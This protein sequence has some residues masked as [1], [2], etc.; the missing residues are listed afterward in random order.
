MTP[1]CNDCNLSGK[2]TKI[3]T[4]SISSAEEVV[5]SY[6]NFTYDGA[7]TSYINFLPQTI[8]ATGTNFIEGIIYAN[9][10]SNME[11]KL[12]NNKAILEAQNVLLSSNRSKIYYRPFHDLTAGFLNLSMS[13]LQPSR[14]DLSSLKNTIGSPGAVRINRPVTSPFYRDDSPDYFQ[15]GEIKPFRA[16]IMGAVYS[17]ALL[18]VISGV[19]PAVGSFGGGTLITLFGHGFSSDMAAVTVYASGYPCDIVSASFNKILCRTRAP[20]LQL[21]PPSL[22]STILSNATAVFDSLSSNNS[23]VSPRVVRHFGSTGSWLY[24]SYRSESLEASVVL[25]SIPWRRSVSIDFTSLTPLIVSQAVAN[26]LDL[27][28]INGYLT[29][30]VVTNFVASFTGS[31]SFGLLNNGSSTWRLID[32]VDDVLATSHYSPTAFRRISLNRGQRYRLILITVSSIEC[33]PVRTDFI[34]TL[35]L[36]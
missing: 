16:S 3:V 14:V 33:L 15:F 32:A 7:L 17:V 30:E 35:Y 20:V 34:V 24:V 1:K 19:S 23:F 5:S 6:F 31:Y 13:I 26:G 9:T 22:N 29:A 18:P 2:T 28:T 21:G 10:L 4:V 25:L 8:W 27:A 11:L 12:G 36:G